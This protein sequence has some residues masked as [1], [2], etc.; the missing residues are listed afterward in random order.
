MR[1]GTMGPADLLEG[2][3]WLD[4]LEQQARGGVRRFPQDLIEQKVTEVL[5]RLRRGRAEGCR[6]GPRPPTL[7]GSRSA[8]T[9]TCPRSRVSPPVPMNPAGSAAGT[10]AC[11]IV[12]REG[13]RDWPAR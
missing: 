5:R 9:M 2:S 13:N 8:H 3:E 6:H 4:P 7:I 10:R 1:N 12:R 11:H